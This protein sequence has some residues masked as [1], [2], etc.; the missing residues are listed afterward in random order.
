MASRKANSYVLIMSKRPLKVRALL[1]IPL[2]LTLI[3]A[4]S[5]A[6][7]T[8]PFFAPLKAGK[9]T[10]LKVEDTDGVVVG[11]IRNLIL[12]TRTGELKY[13]VI[14]SGGFLGVNATL[15]L[16]PAQIMTA[17]TAKRGIVA[18]DTTLDRWRRAPIFKRSEL[19][20]LVQSGG[21]RE[22]AAYFAQRP[23]RAGRRLSVT[24]RETPDQTNA[25]EPILKFASDIVSSRVVNQ[26]QQK[27]GEILDLLV[28]F[29]EPRRSFAIVSSSRLSWRAHEYAVPLR[30]LEATGENHKLLLD[31][32]A[33]ALTEAPVFNQR[34]WES[35]GT[36]NSGRIYRYFKNAQ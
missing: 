33:S 13:A 8:N 12:D 28:S 35:G 20:S 18:I 11:T 26:R 23:G 6:A 24:G 25:P 30:S 14:G 27:M 2:V 17:G 4:L 21:A 1:A 34:A 3:W 36:N 29:E 16:A 19:S 9:L 10:G 22:I 31:A 7:Q 5:G 32:D 15:R